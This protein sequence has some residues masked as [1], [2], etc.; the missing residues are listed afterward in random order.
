[1]KPGWLAGAV[2]EAKRGLSAQPGRVDSGSAGERGRHLN[3]ARDKQYR[4]LSRAGR[5]AAG[6]VTAVPLA[7]VVGAAGAAPLAGL[8]LV[9][10]LGMGLSARRWLALAGRSRVGARSEDDVQRA[11]TPLLAEG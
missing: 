6:C 4:R 2:D 11:L 5:A 10:A 9:I 7:L 3:Y 1:M 8:L